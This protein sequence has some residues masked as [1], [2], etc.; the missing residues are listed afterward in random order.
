MAAQDDSHRTKP[1]RVLVIDMDDESMQVSQIIKGLASDPRIAILRHLGGHS[2]SINEIAEALDMPTST[3]TMH[4][5]V[6]EDAGLV[7]TDLKP[8]SRGL[9]K[10]CVRLYDRVLITLPVGE[11]PS[12]NIIDITMPI[13]AYVDCVAV[14]TCGLTSEHGII[15]ELDDPA[16][17]YDPERM[18]AQLIWFK[19]G[20]LEY[21]FPNRLPPKAHLK[22]LQISLELCSEAPL[23][24]DDWPSDIT[25]W[26]NGVEIG[27]WTSPGDFGG[28]RGAL[29][30]G[31]WEEWNSQYGL[32]KMWKATKDGTF[33]DGNKVSNV[34]LADLAVTEDSYISVRIGIKND[35]ANI[36]GLNIFGRAFGNYPQDIVMRMIFDQL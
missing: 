32:L 9:Q 8:A 29:T 5:R 35:A 14:P 23:H 11:L 16:T 3:V 34:S 4:I 13:G 10:I 17:F 28:T 7:R 27:T 26:I 20:S 1:G 24:N 36:G 33:V 6:L 31:W 19:Q 30:P 21:R 18:N 22:S 25:M 15:G 2:S 12:D